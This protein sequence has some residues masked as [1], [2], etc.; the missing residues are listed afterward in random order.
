M[1][2]IFE[3]MPVPHRLQLQAGQ[4]TGW[5]RVRL[6]S[7]SQE[8]RIRVLDTYHAIRLPSSLDDETF[9]ESGPWF[10]QTTLTEATDSTPKGIWRQVQYRPRQDGVGSVPGVHI[11]LAPLTLELEEPSRFR[12]E[13]H[14][15]TKILGYL[16]PQ[17]AV[18]H[19]TDKSATL[20]TDIR[21]L[22]R[23]QHSLEVTRVAHPSGETTIA[24]AWRAMVIQPRRDVYGWSLDGAGSAGSPAI[25]PSV[26]HDET[27]VLG[28]IARVRNR[29]SDGFLE[30]V[31]RG[32]D[33][34][35]LPADGE[36]KS[37]LIPLLHSLGPNLEFKGRVPIDQAAP[38]L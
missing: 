37:G 9:W 6:A 33:Q 8:R 5:G 11:P 31:L 19:A 3:G 15:Y 13:G 2:P 36:A 21:D 18:G 25:D 34:A 24:V 4:A 20:P 26:V 32:H 14:S 1:E 23:G 22:H 38:S 16:Q 27:G 17:L 28:S 30:S 10:G 29:F 35:M 7:G 12:Y